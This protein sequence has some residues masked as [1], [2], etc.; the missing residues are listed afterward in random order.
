[1]DGG[2]IGMRMDGNHQNFKLTW[3]KKE[4]V[5]R[6]IENLEGEGQN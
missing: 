4:E 6:E 1:M 3:M 2:Q 5:M